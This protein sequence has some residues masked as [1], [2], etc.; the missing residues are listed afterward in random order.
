[1]RTASTI[2][3]AASFTI[4]L[5]VASGHAQTS[6]QDFCKLPNATVIVVE[7]QNGKK[8]ELALRRDGSRMNGSVG[9]DF[10]S[11]TIDGEFSG[12]DVYWEVAFQDASKILLRGQLGNG[13]GSGVSSQ[14]G[15]QSSQLKWTARTAVGCARWPDGK[16]LAAAENVKSQPASTTPAPAQTAG[17]KPKPQIQKPAPVQKAQ[18]AAAVAAARRCPEG[19]TQA[20][21]GECVRQISPLAAPFQLLLPGLGGIDVRIGR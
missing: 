9:S 13:E 5:A 11:A 4:V 12:S 3:A 10:G 16:A 7:L 17:P 8:L 18:P 15:N 2:V 14:A 1:M 19:T 6:I 20:A 21:N